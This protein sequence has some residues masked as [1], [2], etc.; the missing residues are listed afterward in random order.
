MLS[1]NYIKNYFRWEKT[2]LSTLSY[3]Q[4]DYRITKLNR[5]SI[6]KFL[7][8][9]YTVSYQIRPHYILKDCPPSQFTHLNLTHC[10]TERL[11]F[12]EGMGLGRLCFYD[13]DYCLLKDTCGDFYHGLLSLQIV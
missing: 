13:C 2:A 6:R 11:R 7:A 1:I 4:A 8:R 3:L 12:R 10:E 5:K 9:K